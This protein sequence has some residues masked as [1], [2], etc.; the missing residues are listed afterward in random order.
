MRVTDA[1]KSLKTPVP[2]FDPLDGGINAR[3]LF[4]LEAP[5]AKAVA[6]GFVSRNN[7]DE[8][9]RNFFDLN[10]AAGIARRDTVCWNVVPW[11]IGTGTKRE[12]TCNA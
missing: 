8:T 5:G 11:Y 10:M 12:M 9:A 6:S 4:L 2:H 7:P 3:V 1:P